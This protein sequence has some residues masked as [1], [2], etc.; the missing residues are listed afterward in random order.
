MRRWD[1]ALPGWGLA[2]HNDYH[3]PE[4]IGALGRRR[5]HRS[6]DAAMR[7]W[8]LF[9]DDGPPENL[10]LFDGDAE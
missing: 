7:R 2:E 10:E 4:H 8:R 6:I 5:P 1:R 9:P 3:T